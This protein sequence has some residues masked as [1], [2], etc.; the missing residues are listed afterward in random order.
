[1]VRRSI[2]ASVALALVALLHPFFPAR[3]DEASDF[4][5]SVGDRV[6]FSEGSAELGARARF[7]L[8]AQAAWLLRHPGLAVTVEGHAD[9][10]GPGDYNLQLSQQRAE[11]VRQRLVEAGVTAERVRTEGHGRA[12]LVADCASASCAAQNRRA[13][14]V[15]GAPATEAAGGRH[16]A[17]RANA[18]SRR[19][20][21]RLF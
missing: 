10:L 3:A 4:K 17:E 18:A 12:H 19:P 21:R 1:M 15:V 16:S 6:F 9:D 2:L 13:V 14:T 5:S 8:D 11:A 20:P 7:A